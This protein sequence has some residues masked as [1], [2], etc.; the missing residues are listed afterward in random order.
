VGVRKA[1]ANWNAANL[2][3][4]LAITFREAQAGEIED[5]KLERLAIPPVID[6]GTGLPAPVPAQMNSLDQLPNG[7]FTKAFVQFN[8]DPNSLR[9]ETGYLKAGMHEI[10]HVLGL[11]HPKGFSGSSVM[12]DFG[13]S[14]ALGPI[15]SADDAGGNLPTNVRECDRYKASQAPNRPFP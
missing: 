2:I 13:I 10:G 3:T 8:V 1:F 4:G 9:R 12:N 11:G 5:I 15:G 6:P 7:T 14:K